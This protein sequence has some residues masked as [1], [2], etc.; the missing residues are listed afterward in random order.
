MSR[1]AIFTLDWIKRNIFQEQGNHQAESLSQ[2]VSFS[3][4]SMG[5]G[6]VALLQANDFQ[7]CLEVLWEV[8]PKPSSGWNVE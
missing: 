5:R 3:P 4:S 7:L 1:I 2:S 6:T 8:R